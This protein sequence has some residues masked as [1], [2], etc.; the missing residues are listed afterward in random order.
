V[1]S[2]GASGAVFAIIGAEFI[3]LY[4]HRKLM[5]AAGRAR[6]Q[7]LIIFGVMNLAVG[8]L[9]ALPGSAMS[10]DNWAHI[11]GLVGGLILAWFISPILNLKMHPEHPDELLGVDTNPLSRRYWVVSVYATALIIAVF[12]GTNLVGS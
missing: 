1:F 2:V 4:H 9:S 3:Y 5:G 12:L 8:L 11:G 6:R 10:I 7:S